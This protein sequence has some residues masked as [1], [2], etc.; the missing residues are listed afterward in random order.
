MKDLKTAITK[1][2][3]EADD[4]GAVIE[5]LRV[6]LHEL[7]PQA[8]M[9]VDLVR[10]I[11]IERVQAND[12]NPNSVAKNE[13]RLLHTSISHDGYTQPV[14]TVYDESLEK[15]VIVDGFH[16]YLTCRSNEDIQEMTGGTVP[17]VVLDKDINDRMASTVR[18]NRARGKHA[19]TGMSNMVFS[20]LDNGWEDA[21]ICAELG[22][23]ADELVRLKHVTGFSKL[24]D[25]TEYRRSWETRRQIKLR[26][27]WV[28]DKTDK[29]DKTERTA[30]AG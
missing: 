27:D 25:D 22:M 5:A 2:V 16:R 7:S 15:Y 1:A 26:R 21:D 30:N 17:V 9:P 6:H 11:P 12:Y 10:W 18:H 14:V 28:D 4:K 8:G 13:M 20:M 23:E 19:V 24:F 3:E 29:T